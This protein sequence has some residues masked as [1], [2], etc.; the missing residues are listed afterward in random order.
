M[1]L[2]KKY[3]LTIDQVLPGSIAQEV[4]LKSGDV[5]L[6]VNG[7]PLTDLISLQLALASGEA[8]L[9]IQSAAEVWELAIEREED[10]TLGATFQSA[11]SRVRVCQNNCSF[12]FV[13]Q[14]PPGLRPALYLRDDDWRLSFLQGN[15]ITLT[16]LLSE[17][18]Q[19]IISL[20][21]SPLNISIHTTNPQLRRQMLG[22]PKAG[23]I[24]EQLK[25]LANAGI[26]FHGQLVLVPGLNDGEELVRSLWDLA[27]FRESL[28]SLAVVPVG[29]TS[30]RE[31]LPKLR[32]FS[33]NEA[34]FVIAEVDKWQRKFRTCG[35]GT[36]YAS[37]EFFLLAEQPLPEAEYYDD[38]PQ[39]ENGVG[40]VRLFLDEIDQ[41][42]HRL[43][44]TGSGLDCQLATGRLALPIM[45]EVSERILQASSGRVKIEPVAA[46]SFL[47]DRVT[48][49]GLISGEDLLKLPS[50]PRPLLLPDLCLNADGIFLDDLTPEELE[51]KMGRRICVVPAT[52]EGL[53]EFLLKELDR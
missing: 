21:T 17:D 36:Y 25:R 34:A 11:V 45:Q 15:Y 38:Y 12:C 43:A 22:H 9:L 1:K 29:L 16:N 50:D 7:E 24:M 26:H 28:D 41:N 37:D 13:R 47:G 46:E 40:M 30:F 6:Q 14:M 10:E 51:R 33:K 52:G 8:E 20:S 23:E 49:A 5:I 48:V 35:P 39:L 53:V 18:W 42:I 19:R 31:G 4:G 32:P 3:G 2:E 44:E 27:Q